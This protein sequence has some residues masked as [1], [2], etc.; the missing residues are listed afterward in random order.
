VLGKGVGTNYYKG[1]THN[2]AAMFFAAPSITNLPSYLDWKHFTIKYI[3]LDVTTNQAQPELGESFTLSATYSEP[4]PPQLQY[5]WDLG[6][7]RPHVFTT[8][9]T[10]TATYPLGTAP[11]PKTITVALTSKGAVQCVGTVGVIIPSPT[12]AAWRIETAV[13]A[14]DLGAPTA[15]QVNTIGNQGAFTDAFTDYQTDKRYLTNTPTDF[16]IMH[17]S[18]DMTVAGIAFGR[19]LY[20]ERSAPKDDAQVALGASYSY[21]FGLKSRQEGSGVWD[22]QYADGGLPNSGGAAAQFRGSN[23]HLSGTTFSVS[24]S[25]I[26]GQLYYRYRIFPPGASGATPPKYEWTMAWNFKAK[27]IR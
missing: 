23:V 4:I 7:G 5:E 15:D 21:L 20:A 12:F 10:L 8:E 18:Q 27:R 6:D 19:G 17:L 2:F 25:E 3:S 24:G 1:E 26:Q 13:I 11:G 9:P 16:V 22:D 14:T